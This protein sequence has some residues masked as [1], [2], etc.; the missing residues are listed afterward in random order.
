VPTLVMRVLLLFGIGPWNTWGLPGI[1][2]LLALPCWL[3]A[4]ALGVLPSLRIGAILQASGF[5]GV[6]FGA[7]VVGF[8]GGRLRMIAMARAAERA[9]PLVDAIERFEQAAGRPPESLQVLVPEY[10][11][12]IPRRLPPFEIKVRDRYGNRW[13]LEAL[14][15]TGMMNW[16]LLIYFPNDNFP[17][18][19]AMGGW[20]ETL[21]DGWGYLHE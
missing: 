1:V 17:D 8:V 9:E 2:A 7:L 5:A 19:I 13:H 12:R 11:P 18:G 6:I 15:G 16:D 4:C 3:I 10:L 21:G 20:I 14:T